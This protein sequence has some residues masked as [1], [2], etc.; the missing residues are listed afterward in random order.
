MDEFQALNAQNNERAKEIAK[1]LVK[2]AKETHAVMTR[3]EGK[4]KKARESIDTH[5]KDTMW[6]TLQEYIN[7]YAD[8]INNMSTLTG[9]GLY[10][11]NR[12]FY[13]RITATDVENQIHIIIGFV[14]AKEAY[15]SVMKETYKQCVKKLLKRSGLF[16]DDELKRLFI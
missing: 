13:E 8:F 15:D 11:V 6:S 16:T 7:Q 9:V 3:S 12:D 1:I 5:D 10:R 14:H 4:C 2:A